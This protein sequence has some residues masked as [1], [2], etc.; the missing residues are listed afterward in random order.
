MLLSDLPSLIF[1]PSAD[2][3]TIPAGGDI[4][5]AT[6]ISDSTGATIFDN[7]STYTPGADGSVHLAELSELV[8]AAVLTTFSSSQMLAPGA[9]SA[10][11]TLK[12]AVTGGAT[13]KS[14]ALY[15]WRSLTDVKPMFATQMRRRRVIEGQPVPVSVLTF[16]LSHLTLTVG[17][18][19]RLADGGGVSWREA[20]IEPDCS[21]D[22]FTLLA[23]TSEIR[24]ITSAPDG[25]TLLYYVLT[26]Y[27]SGVQADCI[28]FDI[29]R[30]TR[31]SLVTHFVFLN[32]FGVPECVT[33]R[34]KDT[35][36]Q[37]LDSDFGY[38]GREYVRLDPQ[39]TESHKANSG[40]LSREERQAVYDLMSSPYAFVHAD[41][42]LRRI[43]VTDVDSSV[44]RPSNEPQSVALTWRYADERLMR[45]P[46]VTPDT[47]SAAVFAKPPFDKSFS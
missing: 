17:A 19:Y 35:E 39:L 28:R 22:Y 30:T 29:D 10:G 1:S 7:T 20:T 33:F 9:R 34:G 31:P 40:W 27:R 18:A 2:D 14:H 5:V 43:A 46:L 11:C 6:T 42:S 38:A 23:D 25:S 32:L 13:V 12:V 24:Q 15:M 21:S 45:Q 41:G 16:A 26:L 3:L 36:E 4:V 44:G 47:G 8:N 37:D